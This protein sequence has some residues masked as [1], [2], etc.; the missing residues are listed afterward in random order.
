MDQTF[1]PPPCALRLYQ[2]ATVLAGLYGWPWFY[3]RL[4]SRGFGESFLPRL[5]LRL[6]AKNHD[7]RLTRI[8]LHGVSVG[9]IAAAEPLVKELEHQTPQVQLLL[10]TGTETGQTV[11]RRLYPPPKNV[12]YY[13]LDLPWTVRRYLEHLQPTIYAAL[14][15]EI[16]PNFL[17]TAKRRGV[18]LALLNGRLS[19]NSFR[20][21]FRFSCYLKY[22]IQ[23]FDL[24]AAASAEDAERFMALGAP[25][26][27]VFTTGTTKFERRQN[28]ESWT[29]AKIF[30]EIWRPQ[31]APLLLAASTHP[32][33]EEVIIR[34]YQALCR[35]YPALQLALAPRHPERAAPVGQLLSQAGLPFHSWHRLKNGLEQRRE[36]VVLVDTVGDLFA[37]YHLANLVFVGGSLVPHGGQNIL[38]PAA[39]GKVPLY[40]PHLNNFTAARAML[41]SVAAGWPVSNLQ[42]LIQAGQYCLSHPKEMQ[43]RGRRGLR[44]L[45]EHQGAARRQAE[46]LQGLIPG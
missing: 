43:E 21:Y 29:Q 22:I 23:L 15:T 8:W 19:E 3:W 11:A 39:W 7:A 41:E 44:A 36:S 45:E 34:A 6:P 18:K 26:G 33:E 32:G 1:S 14:E 4:K 35:P 17:M 13:P 2:S 10:S 38:E 46:L 16:W 25:P 20:N 24:I 5:G 28:P 31:G 12:F 40:G 27:K 30:Q 37:L 42:E 9:E